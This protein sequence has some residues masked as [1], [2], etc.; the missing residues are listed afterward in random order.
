VILYVT[1]QINNYV[2]Q[3]RA[4]T[5]GGAGAQSIKWGTWKQ[6]FIGLCSKY[7]CSNIS[8]QMSLHRYSSK[9]I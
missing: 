1:F 8:I 5:S 4:E 7:Q 3:G 2:D 6:G 9:C